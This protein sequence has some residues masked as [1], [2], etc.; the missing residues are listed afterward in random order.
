MKILLS[1]GCKNGK[2]TLA[3]DCAVKLSENGGGLY[4]IATMI[5]HD[6]EDLVRIERHI[7][8]RAGKG[9][10]TLEQGMNLPD[11]VTEE[12]ACGTF[13]LDSVTALLTNEMYHD[14]IYEKDAP[15]KVVKD[16]LAFAEK[17]ENAVFVSDF[18]YSS[19]EQYSVFT[20]EYREGLARCDKAL[21]QICDAVCEVCT[22]CITMYKG[23]L[24]I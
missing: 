14:G 24:P 20:E 6:D 13:L 12:N 8:N 5:P 9:F 18:I 16:L 11:C 19:A 2:S 17:V 15:D 7:A 23:E 10:T 4:Y 22:G 21:A 1:G 3:E